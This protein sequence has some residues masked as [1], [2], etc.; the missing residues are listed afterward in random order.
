[1]IQEEKENNR[2][3]SK[4]RWRTRK[5]MG[6]LVIAINKQ[7]GAFG[8]CYCKLCYKLESSLLL[9]N[10][11]TC[12]KPPFTC[13]ELTKT[14]PKTNSLVSKLARQN[15][16]RAWNKRK[17]LGCIDYGLSSI[18][19]Q[20][21]NVAHRKKKKKKL[22]VSWMTLHML[23]DDT[24]RWGGVDGHACLKAMCFTGFLNAFRD[25]FAGHGVG[26]SVGFRIGILEVGVTSHTQI[27]HIVLGC[28]ASFSLLIMFNLCACS[29]CENCRPC[30]YENFGMCITLMGQHH[31]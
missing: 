19:F 2:A 6:S 26:L 30:N 20:I 14:K 29:F 15:I 3:G 31:I 10:A 22:W 25:W 16:T 13:R 9:F 27:H 24:W 7:Y 12:R 18:L 1:M 5:L 23:Q 21:S 17:W 4:F 8:C 11:L 28:L